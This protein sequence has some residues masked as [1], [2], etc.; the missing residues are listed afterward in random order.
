LGGGGGGLVLS[1]QHLP[2][3]RD[4]PLASL[5]LTMLKAFGCKQVN[6]ADSTGVLPGM[7]TLRHSGGFPATSNGH[8]VS[9][10]CSR[11]RQNSGSTTAASHNRH[12]IRQ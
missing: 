2:Y 10:S 8:A 12:V 7:L 3:G 11:I 5:Y 6:F 9:H 4:T 1:N